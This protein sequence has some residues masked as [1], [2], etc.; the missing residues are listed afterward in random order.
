MQG[1]RICLYALL[2]YFGVLF[3]KGKRWPF[4]ANIIILIRSN[5]HTFKQGTSREYIDCSVNYIYYAHLLYCCP[6]Q[7]RVFTMSSDV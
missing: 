5:T 6:V 2:N 1:H 3:G 4:S 7:R